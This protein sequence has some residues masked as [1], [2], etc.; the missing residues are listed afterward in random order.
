MKYYQ[1][2]VVHFLY[3]Q[4]IDRVGAYCYLYVSYGIND[5]VEIVFSRAHR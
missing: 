3:D 1:K 2:N 4:E 5:E